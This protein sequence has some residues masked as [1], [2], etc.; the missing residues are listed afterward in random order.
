M[1]IGEKITKI[2]K[3]NNMTQEQFAEILY[4]SRQ[5]VSKW[6]LD[7]VYPNTE[8]LILISKLFNCSLDYLLKDEIENNDINLQTESEKGRELRIK[9]GVLTYLSFPP[10]FGWIVGIVSI[11][12]QTKTFRNKIQMI[13]SGI[14]I[15]FSL[16]LTIA[17]L[18]GIIL[19][20]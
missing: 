2:R 18:A 10:I 4:V 19:N 9:A 17:M 12:F 16:S 5:S 13:I 3:D 15:V 8:K 6:E 1:T 7:C 11:V 20:L 14:G